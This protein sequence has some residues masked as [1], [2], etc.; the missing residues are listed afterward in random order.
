MAK[1]LVQ[2]LYLVG[3]TG[4]VHY[5]I[6]LS[7]QRSIVA[8]I[9]ML[10]NWISKESNAIKILITSMTI[11]NWLIMANGQPKYTQIMMFIR[12]YLSIIAVQV[13]QH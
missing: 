1:L 13:L 12:Y 4:T 2:Y 5:E 6:A 7:V 9:G 11:S 3:A 10:V 8:P